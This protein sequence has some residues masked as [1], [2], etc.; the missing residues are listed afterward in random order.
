MYIKKFSFG[1]WIIFIVSLQSCKNQIKTEDENSEVYGKVMG[2]K[3]PEKDIVNALKIAGFVGSVINKMVCT[4][5]YES[6]WRDAS[7]NRNKNGSI[8]IGLFQINQINWKWC[9]VT[10]NS[11]VDIV[12]NTK[13]AKK[14]YN[15]LKLNAWYGYKAKRGIC[16]KYKVGQK[17][18]LKLTDSDADISSVLSPLDNILKN[19]EFATWGQGSIHQELTEKQMEES[20]QI[21]KSNLSE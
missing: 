14:I 6:Q 5:Y 1:F 18:V 12:T 19:G 20:E 17:G 15:V 11:L 21:E 8:D 13:C 10:K 7:Y 3:V 16:D 4:A 2:N 9:K